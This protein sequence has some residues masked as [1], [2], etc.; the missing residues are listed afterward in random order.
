MARD[1]RAR[2]ESAS[3]MSALVVALSWHKQ[4][5]VV[6]GC[7]QSGSTC[8]RGLE[9]GVVDRGSGLADQVEWAGLTQHR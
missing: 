6:S 1:M 7:R 4:W 8:W 9:M 2:Q 3:E 5:R